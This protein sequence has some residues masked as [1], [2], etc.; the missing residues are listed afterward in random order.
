MSVSLTFS[1]NPSLFPFLSLNTAHVLSRP[2]LRKSKDK[3]SEVLASKV[4]YRLQH[5][6]VCVGVGVFPHAVSLTK[7]V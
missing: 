1:F 3:Q 7:F 4:S 6:C 2:N 5:G